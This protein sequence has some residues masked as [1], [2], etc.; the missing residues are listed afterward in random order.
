MR[1]SFPSGR[2]PIVLSPQ[3]QLPAHAGLNDPLNNILDGGLRSPDEDHVA[4]TPGITLTDF[5]IF[6]NEF[7]NTNAAARL[8]WRGDLDLNGGTTLTDLTRFKAH[9][10]AP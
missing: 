3:K 6:K 7:N 8:D 1:C 10:N 5:V 4:A 2:I 9:F